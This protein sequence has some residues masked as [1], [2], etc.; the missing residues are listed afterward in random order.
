MQYIIIIINNIHLQNRPAAISVT[1]NNKSLKWRCKQVSFEKFL[2]LFSVW[3]RLNIV[4]QTV[5]GSRSSMT[6]GSLTELGFQCWHPVL[7]VTGK[8]EA[9]ARRRCCCEFNHLGHV[10]RSLVG[11]NEV[12]QEAQFVEN[13][14]FYRQPSLKTGVFKPVLRHWQNIDHQMKWPPTE[15]HN[16]NIPFNVVNKRWACVADTLNI[17]LDW[18]DS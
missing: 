11:V 8:P 15:E 3:F 12:R 17:P 9:R 4:W 1:A 10:G 18:D 16:Y 13:S 2:E 6:E 5:P 14:W 7:E